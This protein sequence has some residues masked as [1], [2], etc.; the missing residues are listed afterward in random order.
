M[1]DNLIGTD[2]EPVYGMNVG[3]FEPD[4]LRPHLGAH[5]AGPRP[6]QAAVVDATARPAGRPSNVIEQPRR[7][8]ATLGA[9]AAAAV[10]QQQQAAESSFIT[11]LDKVR[12]RAVDPMSSGD[13]RTMHPKSKELL[14]NVGRALF[15][16]SPEE[17][18]NE[19][20]PQDRMNAQVLES[21]NQIM[22]LKASN[23]PVEIVEMIFDHTTNPLISL[24]LSK[25]IYDGSHSEDK[26]HVNIVQPGTDGEMKREKQTELHPADVKDY[27]DN[28]VMTKPEWKMK[29]ARIQLNNEFMDMFFTQAR[30]H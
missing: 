13:V 5:L 29:K 11:P 3:V 24:H 22:G 12:N 9:Q 26:I 18:G 10:Q 4:S 20:E 21:I 1:R 16:E 8:R 27:L 19:I 7:R 23:G 17:E 25:P 15:Q 30:D 2:R 14:K 28:E 6:R